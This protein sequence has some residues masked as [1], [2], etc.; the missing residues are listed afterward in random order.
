MPVH[1]HCV[2]VK[3]GA[4]SSISLPF[5]FL[6]HKAEGVTTE[7]TMISETTTAST[8]SG[9][10]DTSDLPPQHTCPESKEHLYV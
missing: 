9:K 8:G 3:Y 7:A 10:E 2:L 1:V 4:T 5:S 6:Y